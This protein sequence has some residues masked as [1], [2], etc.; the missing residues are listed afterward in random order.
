MKVRIEDQDLR[1][2]ISEDEL[3]ALLSGRYLKVKTQVMDKSFVSVIASEGAGDEISLKLISGKD[4]TCLRL[5][6]S[7]A[8]LQELSDMGRSRSGLQQEIDG[9][10]VFLQVDVRADS[11]KRIKK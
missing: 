10:S 6:V 8:R 5:L 11:R 2:K 7:P 4:E 9:V 1:F 3:S